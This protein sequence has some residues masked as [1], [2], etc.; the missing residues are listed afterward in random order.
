M[1]QKNKL[2]KLV[3][4]AKENKAGFTIKLNDLKPYNSKEGYAC[5][6]TNIKGKNLKLLSRKVLFIAENGFSQIK[7]KLFIGGWYNEEDKR[8]YI[9]LSFIM[10]KEEAVKTG[11]LFNQIAVFNFENLEALNL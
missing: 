7:E 9:D 10:N 5:A 3:S 4:I 11:K 8:Y 6:I 2:I 1:K